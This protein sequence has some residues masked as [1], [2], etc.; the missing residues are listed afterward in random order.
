MEV[1]IIDPNLLKEE[2]GTSRWG[3]FLLPRLS[4]GWEWGVGSQALLWCNLQHFIV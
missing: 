2:G 3:R 1:C 4:F